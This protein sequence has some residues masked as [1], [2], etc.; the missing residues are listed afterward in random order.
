MIEDS[1][2]E[3]EKGGDTLTRRAKEQHRMGWE[4]A[5]YHG[6]NI[7]IKDTDLLLLFYAL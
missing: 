2:R 7:V 5:Q 1:V 3:K 4:I 6:R